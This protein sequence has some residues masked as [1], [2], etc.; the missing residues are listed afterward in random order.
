MNISPVKKSLSVGDEFVLK[1]SCVNIP[2]LVSV[3]YELSEEGVI[4]P[5]Y[6]DKQTLSMTFKALK[7]GSVTVEI[8]YGSIVKHCSVEVT[9]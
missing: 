6:I 3:N 7:A 2:D 5:V 1:I 8:S 4:E 9:D